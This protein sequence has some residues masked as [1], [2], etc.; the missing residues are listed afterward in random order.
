MVQPNA[1][2]AESLR[3][4]MLRL[5]DHPKYRHPAYWAVFALFGDGAR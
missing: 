3:Q 4:A 2:K 5:M 1:S